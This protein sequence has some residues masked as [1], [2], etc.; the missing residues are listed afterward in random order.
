MNGKEITELILL[1]L[2]L[3]VM[4][5]IVAQLEYMASLL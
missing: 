3:V 4:V 2:I 5:Y 1:F